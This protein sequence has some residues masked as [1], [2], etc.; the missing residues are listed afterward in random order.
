ME[1]RNVDANLTQYTPDNGC[2]CQSE[3]D[4]ITGT[5]CWQLNGTRAAE[6]ESYRFVNFGD[7]GSV[8]SNAV[9]NC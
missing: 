8:C 6:T 7:L 1:M 5:G 4:A 3:C 2:S 9:T